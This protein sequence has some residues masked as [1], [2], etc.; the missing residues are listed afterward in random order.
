[1]TM[2]AY[3]GYHRS[4]DDAVGN[5]L[6]NRANGRRKLLISLIEDF[7]VYAPRHDSKW[8]PRVDDKLIFYRTQNTFVSTRVIV[9]F[10]AGD[11]RENRIKQHRR[12]TNYSLI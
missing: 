9:L 11:E 2:C 4:V 7:L 12:K 3:R 10:L 5:H 1:M 8:L 6:P